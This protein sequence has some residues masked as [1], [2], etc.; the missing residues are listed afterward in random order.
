MKRRWRLLREKLELKTPQERCW[1][2]ASV[3]ATS[4]RRS[5]CFRSDEETEAKPAKS[6]HRSGNKRVSMVTHLKGP[7]VLCPV[8][9]MYQALQVV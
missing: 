6:V 2:K 1:P 4:N 8:F 5:T 7:G 3:F 9:L